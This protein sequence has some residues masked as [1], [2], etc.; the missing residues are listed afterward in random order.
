MSKTEQFPKGPAPAERK[1]DYGQ[2]LRTMKR[3]LGYML[4]NYRFS[5]FLVV[6]CIIGSALATLRGTLFM[7][8]LIDDYI[9]PLTQAAQPDFSALSAALLRVGCVYGA[10]ILCA[11][12][13]N[14][15]MVNVSQGTMRDLR[16][17]LFEHMEALPVR[18][19]DTHAHGDIM[20]VY[21]NDVDTL[22]QLISQSIP[23]LI[24]S[25]VTILTTFASMV[26]LNLPLT[27]IT[28]VMVCLM[29]LVTSRIAGRSAVYFSRQQRDLGTVNGYIEEMMNGQKVVKV[30]CHEEKSLEQFRL[31]NEQLR[32]SAE[33]AN[34]FSNITMPVNGN[35]GNISYVLCAVAGAILALNG[36]LGLTLGTLVSFLTLNKNSTQPVSQISQQTNSIVMAMAGA[37]RVFD[38]MDE[39]PEEDNGYVELVNARENP[40]GS[41][42]EVPERTGVWAWRHP[43]RADGTVTYTKLSGDVTFNDVDFGYDPDK[44]VLHGIRLYATPGQKIAFVGS[45]GAGKT[46]ITNLINRFYDIADGKIRY[47]GININKIKKPDLRRSLGMVLQDTHLFTG[48][49]MDNIRYGRLDATDGE[50]IAAARLANA[51]GFIRRLPEGYQTVLT[52]DGSSLSQGQRQLLAI[53]RAAVADPPVLILDEAT[54]SIDTRTEAL[55]QEGMDRLMKG[56]TTFVIAHRLS[57]VKNA[58]CIMVLE[59]GR[60]IERGTHE[61]LLEEKGR[62]YQL[63]TGNQ[64]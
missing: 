21:T 43:H 16:V 47:D 41:L 42:T 36:Y 51:D 11:Y 55:V 45:T 63:Y 19:F 10:G 61:Q 58:D 32:D 1:T 9:V 6:V 29:L 20:S 50:C 23:Q 12:T 39:K 28:L 18:Y 14:R 26:L 57:T 62:Y 59:Q 22:R 13:Y 52:R 54:S 40:D 3:V 7:Q 17:E 56:R 37:Q 48:T 53:A 15:I 38:L 2:L 33:K 24:N 4:R 31:L 8:S 46:T 60:I 27:L 44:I 35:L 30:F 49:V 5:F 25:A 64:A 34:I